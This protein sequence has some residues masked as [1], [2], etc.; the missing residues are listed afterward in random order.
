MAMKSWRKK[1][2]SGL[3]FRNLPHA[4]GL[5]TKSGT[6]LNSSDMALNSLCIITRPVSPKAHFRKY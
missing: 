3:P 4:C 1:Y 6:V 5:G 2:V